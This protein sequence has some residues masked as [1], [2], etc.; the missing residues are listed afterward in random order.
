VPPPV[1]LPPPSR[2]EQ[3]R[4]ALAVNALDRALEGALSYHEEAPLDVLAYVALG[5]VAEAAGQSSLAARA[6]GSIVDLWGDRAE[7]RRFAA[8]RL[9]GMA[10]QAPRSLVV[11]LYDAAVADRA[12][13]PTGHRLL[14]YAKLAA[15]DREGAFRAI[16]RGLTEGARSARA[17]PL[18]DLMRRDAAI[19]AAALVHEQP[20]QRPAIESR[21]AALGALLATTP[22]VRFVLHW[23]TDANDVDLHVSDAG[24]QT[25]NYSSRDLRSGGSLLADVTTGFGPEGFVIPGRATG[26]PYSLRAHYFSRGAMGF[27]MG[28]VQI[29]CHDGAGGVTIE[30]RPFV[31]QA[32]KGMVDLGKVTSC[33]VAH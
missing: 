1:P 33:P 7:L 9:E 12:D 30:D 27:G 10:D 21:L 32:D 11:D 17:E 2:F 6:Y 15:G 4:G 16:E 24:G 18:L 31:I 25:A 20:S 23:E 22:S 29:V 28:K 13:Q 19:L 3:V 26:F 8:E 5:E 14:A